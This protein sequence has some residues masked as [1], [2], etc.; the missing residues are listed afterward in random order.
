MYS[1][2]INCIYSWH[3]LSSQT[4]YPMTTCD[5]I[6]LPRQNTICYTDSFQ[7]INPTPSLLSEK[8]PAYYS[9][10]VLNM[11]VI[12]LFL[13]QW[14]ACNQQKKLIHFQ[15]DSSVLTHRGDEHFWA[16]PCVLWL[17]SFSLMHLH[18]YISSHMS[19]RALRKH[20]FAS[21]S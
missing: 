15:L 1:L 20:F 19:A 17:I 18:Q 14:T 6:L 4:Q 8:D 11:T 9:V 16:H 10:S 2:S 7:V 13:H 5:W 3:Q 21:R 12:I